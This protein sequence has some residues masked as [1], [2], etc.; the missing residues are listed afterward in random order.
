[1]TLCEEF[2]EDEDLSEWTLID[3]R[4]VDYD[5][6]QALDYQIDQLNNKDKSTLSK[7]W[8]FV[9]TE[10]QDQTQSQNKIRF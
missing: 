6:E 1:M 8:E 7:I 3:E 5:S 10:L 2:G 4:K 9:S